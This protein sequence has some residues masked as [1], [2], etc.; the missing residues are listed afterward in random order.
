MFHPTWL[1]EVLAL[2]VQQKEGEGL[3][4]AS[5]GIEEDTEYSQHQGEHHP[6]PLGHYFG[7]VQELRGGQRAKGEP[8]E[9]HADHQVGEDQEGAAGEDPPRS[10]IT[11][12]GARRVI[13]SPNRGN[14]KANFDDTGRAITE[15]ITAIYYKQYH[16]PS[17][18]DIEIA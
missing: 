13:N 2:A 10:G 4:V 5:S 11:Q 1:E 8:G 12:Y 3:F 15:L 9:K 14:Q 17:N 16:S 7:L 6:T 18:A